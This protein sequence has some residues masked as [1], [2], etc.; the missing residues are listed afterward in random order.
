M[1]CQ[2]LHWGTATGPPAPRKFHLP[3]IF[4]PALT[5]TESSI[6]LLQSANPL[7]PG[8][9]RNWVRRTGLHKT[10]M[11]NAAGDNSHRV[12]IHQSKGFLAPNHSQ[13]QHGCITSR[14]VGCLAMAAAKATCGVLHR[15]KRSDHP[16][17]KR[18]SLEW[19]FHVSRCT[20]QMIFSNQGISPE[21]LHSV[22][23]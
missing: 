4:L 9:S 18:K 16:K 13:R 20:D 8:K 21:A 17:I 22:D 14:Q 11:Q 6:W 3:H 15:P 10:H 1:T 7:P 19:L 2:I 5:N 12:S 23:I